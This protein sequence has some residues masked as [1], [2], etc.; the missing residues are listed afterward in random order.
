MVLRAPLQPFI[1]DRQRPS[2][3]DCRT[4]NGLD[5]AKAR[6]D[7]RAREGDGAGSRVGFRETG[8]FISAIQPTGAVAPVGIRLAASS[9][10]TH[11]SMDGM[12]DRCRDLDCSIERYRQV[13][14]AISNA[15]AIEW[16]ERFVRDLVQLKAQL[17]ARPPPA[18]DA[19]IGAEQHPVF[20]F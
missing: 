10:P 5:P 16:I 2:I 12:C 4:L 7:L 20:R 18:R 19:M 8:V 13:V 15:V 11:T 1:N 17:H 14:A 3:D 6:R 9:L